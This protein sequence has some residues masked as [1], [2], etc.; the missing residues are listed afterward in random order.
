M[1]PVDVAY[2]LRWLE[3]GDGRRRIAFREWLANPADPTDSTA[4]DLQMT[5]SRT[6]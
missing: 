1:G 2:A 3:L 4:R 5:R 6:T